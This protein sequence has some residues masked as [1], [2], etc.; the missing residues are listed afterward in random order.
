M[1]VLLALL[2]GV[3]AAASV[4]LMLDRSLVRFLF[5]LA[6]LGNAAN[7]VIFA[8]GRLT[9]GA[10]ALIAK[11]AAAP[12]GDVSNALPQAL[13]LTAIVISF[14]LFAFALSLVHRAHKD[15]GTTD[16]ETLTIAEGSDRS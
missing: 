14:G 2:A 7:L 10:P 15:L 4:W 1:D 6:L 8:G 3:L 13:I 11:G 16:S 5:G 12:A 9:E